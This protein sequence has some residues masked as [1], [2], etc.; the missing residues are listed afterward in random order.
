MKVFLLSFILSCTSL[1]GI[2]NAH[3]SIDKSILKNW[4]P[5]P[6]ELHPSIK[7]AFESPTKKSSLTIRNFKVQEQRLLKTQVNQWLKDYVS[8][9]FNIKQKKP[10]KLEGG[11]LAYFVE[12][13]HKE[14][15]NTFQQLISVKDGQMTTLT[16]RSTEKTELKVCKDALFS[17][18]NT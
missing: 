14:F 17:F 2:E 1:Y 8:Y 10:I 12:A 6:N 9:G 16:C 7:K 11:A 18:K 3:A 13:Y 4:K 5:L 15:N